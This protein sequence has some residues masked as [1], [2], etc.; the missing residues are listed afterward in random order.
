MFA[1]RCFAQFTFSGMTPAIIESL[2]E[3]SKVLSKGRKQNKK[4]ALEGTFCAYCISYYQ[5]GLLASLGSPL[6]SWPWVATPIALWPVLYGPCTARS[7]SHPSRI[8]VRVVSPV[9]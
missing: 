7:A 1:I 9:V 6:S 3:H 5:V 2:V 4:K 8:L